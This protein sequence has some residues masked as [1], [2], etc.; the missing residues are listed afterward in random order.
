[1]VCLSL[2]YTS[3][4]YD[5]TKKFSILFNK[6]ENS[7]KGADPGFLNVFFKS[8][9]EKLGAFSSHLCTKIGNT[10]RDLPQIWGT[11]PIQLGHLTSFAPQKLLPPPPRWGTSNW[12][13]FPLELGRRPG[14]APAVF[15]GL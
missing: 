8:A 15:I 2:E 12:A 3:I 6:R 4:T 9:K 7:F 14:S 1:M 13:H 5:R 11:F 10:L